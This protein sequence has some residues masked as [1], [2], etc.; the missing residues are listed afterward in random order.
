[1]WLAW[2]RNPVVDECP[3]LLDCVLT[4]PDRHQHAAVTRYGLAVM[5]E[6]QIPQV[7]GQLL[8]HFPVGVEKPDQLAGRLSAHTRHSRAK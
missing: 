8:D 3:H 5:V 6:V 4:T 7:V 1:M 2:W